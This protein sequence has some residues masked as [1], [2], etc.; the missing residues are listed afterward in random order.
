M[1]ISKMNYSALNCMKS[2]CTGLNVFSMGKKKANMEKSVMDAMV[3]WYD[4]A[5]QGATNESMQANP[6]LAD[7]SGNG[8]DAACGNFAWKGMSGVGGYYFQSIHHDVSTN[9]YV[10][11]YNSDFSVVTFKERKSYTAAWIS[12]IIKKNNIGDNVHYKIEV[13]GL[14]KLRQTYPNVKLGD[15]GE[16]YATEIREDGVYELNYTSVYDYSTVA[17][18]NS[19]PGAPSDL[20]LDVTIRQIPL[21]PHALVFDG[22]DDKATCPAFHLGKDWTLL[23]DIAWMDKVKASAGISKNPNFFVYNNGTEDGLTCYINRDIDGASVP[24]TIICMNSQLGFIDRDYSIIEDAGEQTN[25]SGSESI[26]M[27][28]YNGA[29]FTTM[30]LRKFLLFNRALSID[31]IKWVKT[32]LM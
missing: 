14:S 29:N 4:L 2:N 23:F 30:A 17:L 19:L 8:H 31:E 13:S 1:N 5:K 25:T 28:C 6:V 20:S 9:K 22:V 32:N 3:L 21:Y 24:N 18:Y 7:H 16:N 15:P 12:S 26:I 11:E 27:F 10:I